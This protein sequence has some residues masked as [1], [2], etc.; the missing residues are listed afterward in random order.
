MTIATFLVLLLLALA[1]NL[2][3]AFDLP[4]LATIL[5]LEA[6]EVLALISCQ[7]N[8][9]LTPCRMCTLTAAV[10]SEVPRLDAKASKKIPMAASRSTCSAASSSL[11]AAT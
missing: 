8:F 3:L 10:P 5:F 9:W 7:R 6:T 2:Q 11:A 1:L 4:F